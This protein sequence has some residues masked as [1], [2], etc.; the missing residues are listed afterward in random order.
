MNINLK[1]S[2]GMKLIFTSLL[3]L[4]LMIPLMMVSGLIKE[5]ENRRTEAIQEVSSRWGSEQKLAGPVLVVPYRYSYIEKTD[6][7]NI[8]RT[9]VENAY[10]LPDTANVIG[11]LVAEKRSRGLYEVI[12]YSLKG[13][14]VSG[15]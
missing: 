5:R 10:F 3:V 12:L 9:S 8:T 14:K 7:K 2:L 11:T 13:L 1:G 4:V 15:T 6:N